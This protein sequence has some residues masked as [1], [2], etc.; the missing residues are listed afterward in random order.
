MDENIQ[1]PLRTLGQL[2]REYEEKY[3]QLEELSVG[4]DADS[5]A[6]QLRIQAEVTTDRFRSAQMPLLT[7]LSTAASEEE[8]EKAYTTAI[9]LCRCFDE[10]RILFQILAQRFLKSEN[11]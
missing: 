10:M 8:S 4:T 1:D 9:S 2:A 6:R 11:Y 3:K 5:L 7:L